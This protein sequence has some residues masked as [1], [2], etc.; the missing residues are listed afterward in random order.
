MAN[1]TFRKR[2][3]KWEYRF[4]AA[5]IDGKRKQIS[6]GGFLT[7]KDA[8]IAG[9]KAFEEYHTTGQSFK[10]SEISFN[11]L[12]KEYMEMYVKVELAPSTQRRYE[13]M[14]RVHLLPAF[15][16]FKLKSISTKYV[17][18]YVNKLRGKGY[19]RNHINNIY[20]LLS[21]TIQYAVFPLQYIKNNPCENVKI[22]RNEGKQKKRD[23]LTQDEINK[24]IQRFPPGSRFY[25]PFM[26]GYYTGVRISECFGITWEDIDL[27][28][29]VIKIQK[30]M[31]LKNGNANRKTSKYFQ[32]RLKTESS[33]RT[34]P[35]GETLAS[36]LKDVQIRQYRDEIRQGSDY[37][38]VYGEM[39]DDTLELL[40]Q[41]PKSEYNGNNRIRPLFSY[42]DGRIMQH[43]ILTHSIHIINRELGIKFDYHTL[44]HTHATRL[45][46]AGAPIK[47]VSSRLGHSTVGITLNTYVHDTDAMAKETVDIFEKASRIAK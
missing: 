3:N 47:A 13:T 16:K 21:A 28:N 14:F 23:A 36:I 45:L 33:R 30:Q 29:K 19:T 18:Q 11:D 37:V 5:K 24:I 17:Q 46:E 27:E 2:G 41:V 9:S 40:H 1:I 22:P 8:A 12:A 34:I 6:K 7:K 42:P 31:L 39:V 43:D 10:P 38:I 4:E 25:L 26:V 15:G 44:R 35:I 32:H 20:T